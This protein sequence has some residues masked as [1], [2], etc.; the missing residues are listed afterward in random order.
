MH[1]KHMTLPMTCAAIALTFAM[2]AA[3]SSTWAGGNELR[4]RAGLAGGAGDVSGQ[5]DFRD[6]DSRRKF[7]V[8]VEG[9]APGD[10]F[11]V[12]VAGAIVGKVVV[13]EFG[14]GDVNFDTNFE[15]GIDDPA[16]QFPGN[17][18]MLDGG[19]KIEIGPLTGTLQAK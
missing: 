19:E 2:L 9:F 17:F 12:S 18:P 6:R 10:M 4:L 14:I 11:D 1:G 5:A 7:S 13:N 3:S 8:E 15:A 16:T